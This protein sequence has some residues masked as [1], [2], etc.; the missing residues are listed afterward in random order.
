MIENLEI[1]QTT[2][3]IGD[4]HGRDLWRDI[5]IRHPHAR[6]VFLGDYTDP[7]P[8]DKI[9][10]E[11]VWDN[12][13]RLLSFKQLNRDRV[14]LLIGNHDAQYLFSHIWATNSY[15][16]EIQTKL[17]DFYA[18]RNQFLDIALEDS[19]LLFTHAGVSKSWMAG[20]N[21]QT[22]TPLLPTLKR[23]IDIRDNDKIA[24]LNAVGFARRGTLEWGGPLWADKSEL[25]ELPS[26][27]L[28]IVGH[29][30]TD[31]IFMRKTSPD[32]GIVFCDA[33][34]SGEYL[35]IES[36]AEEHN[37]YIMNFYSD[38]AEL[39]TTIQCRK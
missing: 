13:M 31:H 36:S 9:S 29:N 34:R 28:Q 32:A 17:K 15:M 6:F 21:L 23:M 27:Y 20:A 30:P 24:Q 12:L 38:S 35:K 39:L 26:G 2:I 3:V 22:R 11:E 16:W 7:I 19:G 33:L 5:V 18:C 1:K 37:L 14:T 4:I 8:S 25:W 10:V